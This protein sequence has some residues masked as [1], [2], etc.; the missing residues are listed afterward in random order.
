M[1]KCLLL[2]KADVMIT[3]NE[4][5]VGSIRITEEK[6]QTQFIVP[7]SL[8]YRFTLKNICNESA[9]CSN[10]HNVKLTI[11]PDKTLLEVINKAFGLNIYDT[12]KNKFGW[13]QIVKEISPKEISEFSLVYILGE[14]QNNVIFPPLPLKEALQAIKYNA[15]NATLIVSQDIK[16][17]ARFKLDSNKNN[18]ITLDK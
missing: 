1:K 9:F 3:D 8:Y 7:T 11:E 2:E 13:N 4:D 6:Y 12:D 5:I 15:L 18:I 10:L 14:K 16:E 17:I